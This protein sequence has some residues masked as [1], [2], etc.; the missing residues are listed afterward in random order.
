VWG[1]AF[2]GEVKWQFAGMIFCLLSYQRSFSSV[3]KNGSSVM[4]MADLA[5]KTY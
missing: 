2:N 3:M 1:Q 4:E 5:V